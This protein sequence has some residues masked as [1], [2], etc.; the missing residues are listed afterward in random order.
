MMHDTKIQFVE[1]KPVNLKGYTLIEG[2]PGM[3]LVGT[4]AAKYLVEKLKFEQIGHMDSDIF[5]PL[6]RIHKGIPRYPSRIYV[7]EEKKLV[8][9]ISEQIIPR[10]LTHHFGES[11]IEW[12]KT[13]GIQ[14]IISLAGINTG[15]PKDQT[16]YGI[17]SNVKSKKVLEENKISVIKEGITTGVTALMLLELRDEQIEAISIMGT[18]SIGADYKAAANLLQKLN[19]ILQLNIDT[20]PLLKE[21]KE[22]EKEL[23]N[24]FEKMRES[25][26]TVQK[27]EDKSP[28]MYT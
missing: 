14:R 24:Q 11:I 9:L 23:L 19:Q 12:V 10:N 2:F 13:K 21:A 18:V 20:E 17:A 15:D 5:V 27:L 3:G 6:I 1:T 26:E 4:I 25:H 16:I 7:K 8:V 28:L 22:T